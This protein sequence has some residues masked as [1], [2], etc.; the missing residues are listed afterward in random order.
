MFLYTE[1]LNLISEKED[2]NEAKFAII[3]VP[4]D[5]TETNIPGQ[6]FGPNAIRESFL[7]KETGAITTKTYDAGNLIVVSGNAL[8]TLERL[9]ET[10]LDLHQYNNN[11]IPLILGGEHTVTLGAIM[12]LTKKHPDLQILSFD[13][14][15]DLKNEFQG[16]KLSHS[17]VMRRISELGV[18][19]TV[20]GVRTAGEEEK[21]FSKNINTNLKKIDFKKPTYISIDMDVFDPSYAPGVGDPETGGMNPKDVLEILNKKINLVGA[22]IVEVNPMVERYITPSLAADLMITILDSQQ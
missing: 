4:F 5:S 20:I 14:H 8:K 2:L 16:E 15:F 12:A 11:T 6:R 19:I 22:D 17:S 13:A 3:G 9:E 7:S 21:I 10:I 1:R 18:P